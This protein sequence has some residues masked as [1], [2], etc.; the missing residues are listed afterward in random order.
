MEDEKIAEE[1]AETVPNNPN[2]SFCS[3]S[4]SSDDDCDIPGSRNEVS[5]F[6]DED[7]DEDIEG[8][9]EKPDRNQQENGSSRKRGIIRRF[10]RNSTNTN[11]KDSTATE[12]GSGGSTSDS[13]STRTLKLEQKRQ[14]KRLSRAQAKRH[15]AS[16]RHY[17]RR[18]LIACQLL[19]SSCEMLIIEKEIGKELYEQLKAQ[20]EVLKTPRVVPSSVQSPNQKS[21]IG[22]AWSSLAGAS[23]DETDENDSGGEGEENDRQAKTSKRTQQQFLK[24]SEWM[25]EWDPQLAD[26]L[27]RIS[28]GAGYKCLCWLLFQLLLHANKKRGYDAR[29]RYAL[30]SLAVAVLVQDI[31][32]TLDYRQ[33]EENDED[34]TAWKL[35]NYTTWVSFATRKFEQVEHAIAD[36]LIKLAQANEQNAGAEATGSQNAAVSLEDLDGLED[37]VQVVSVKDGHVKKVKGARKQLVR[38]LKIGAVGITAGTLLAVTGGMAAP[39]IA[40]ALTFMGM[41]A[42]ATTFVSL[43]STTAVVHIFGVAGGSLAAYKMKRRTAGLTDFSIVESAVVGAGKATKQKDDPLNSSHSFFEAPKEKPRFAKWAEKAKAFTDKHTSNRNSKTVSQAGAD[44]S[45]G[46]AELSRTICISGWLTDRT[47]FQRPWG[48]TPTQPKIKDKV[49]ILQRFYRVY[50]PDLIP[51]CKNLL[52]RWKSEEATFWELL[53]DKYGS[54]PDTLLPLK[55]G[56]LHDAALTEDELKLLDK[57]IAEIDEVHGKKKK[58]KHANLPEHIQSTIAADETNIMES[59]GFHNADDVNNDNIFPSEKF[60]FDDDSISLHEQTTKAAASEQQRQLPAPHH[61]QRQCYASVFEQ[62][63]PSKSLDKFFLPEHLSTVWDFSSRYVIVLRKI[64]ISVVVTLTILF[65]SLMG[66]FL[67]LRKIWRRSLHSSLGVSHV[68]EV[69]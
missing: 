19:Q 66:R 34:Y 40:G 58:S 25:T 24:Q 23:G 56:P 5:M 64:Y 44:G 50:N 7:D 28:P 11:N 69:E 35:K 2:K 15:L 48:I 42:V 17:Q 6:L 14:N 51:M 47:D 31:E 37:E 3:E 9:R 39:A 62:V 8:S 46:Q 1:A 60:S 57:L 68:D 52:K 20:L 38:G 63:P 67:Y 53:E 30:K 54:N 26:H 43:A 18:Y 29:V 59:Q 12:S 16:K 33:G 41:G 32:H 21:G 61:H 27:N 13:P 22:R 36:R 55:F 45:T 10:G 4:V 65:W 49:E